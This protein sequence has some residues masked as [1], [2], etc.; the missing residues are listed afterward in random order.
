MERL[1]LKEALFAGQ[2]A[3]GYKLGTVL[4][5]GWFWSRVNGCCLLYRGAG[6]DSVDFDDVLAVAD[7]DASEMTVP[8]YMLHESDTTYFYVMRRANCC[9]QIERT[10]SAA[11]KVPIGAD[12]AL[13]ALKPNSVFEVNAEQVDGNRVRFVWWYCPINQEMRPVRFKVYGDGGT[14]QIDYEN[15]IAVIAYRGRRFYGFDSNAL[16]AGRYLFAVQA[17]DVD[18]IVDGSPLQVT[19]ELDE[20]SPSEIEILDVQ[21]V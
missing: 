20:R 19:V 15:P 17:E 12:G 5:L 1:W 13:A 18:G 3:N 6:M 9:G 14:G 4:S 21:A 8:D 16:D 11:V 2:T 7:V 10:L